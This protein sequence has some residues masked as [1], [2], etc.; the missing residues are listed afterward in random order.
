MKARNMQIPRW[1]TASLCGCG[2]I[3]V[4]LCCS[5][6]YCVFAA[7]IPPVAALPSSATEVN[8][9]QSNYSGATTDY[10]WLVKAKITEDE[11][12]EYVAT[13]GLVPYEGVNGLGR[14]P[15]NP[16]QGHSRCGNWWDPTESM[17]NTYYDGT[18]TGSGCALSKHENGYAYYRES[19]G[20]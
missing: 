7:K 4:L 14:L 3:L 6:M 13:L 20:Y 9:F 1:V 15:Q 18:M 12:Q 10:F 17:S 5:L 19:V 2:V 11:F 8:E 16:W